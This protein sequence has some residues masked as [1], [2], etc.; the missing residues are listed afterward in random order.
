MLTQPLTS[1][2]WT[3]EYS[4]YRYRLVLVGEV[5]LQLVPGVPVH[6]ELMVDLLQGLSHLILA[7]F[8]GVHLS[9]QVVLWVV[10]HQ[11]DAF[12]EIV[13]SR[14]LFVIFCPGKRAAR[15]ACST[16]LGQQNNAS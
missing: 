10:V 5:P 2:I 4:T 1:F 6:P 3:A 16:G 15:T 13:V 14:A 7:A 11:I 9:H 8:D 12:P